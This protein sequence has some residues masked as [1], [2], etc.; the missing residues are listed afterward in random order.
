MKPGEKELADLLAKKKIADDLNE[1]EI[2]AREQ[3]TKAAEKYKAAI[4]EHVYELLRGLEW[5]KFTGRGSRG[6]LEADLPAKHELVQINDNLCNCGLPTYRT[7]FGSVCFRIYNK[8]WH[9]SGK[10]VRADKA[11]LVKIGIKLKRAVN[12]DRQKMSK[13]LAEHDVTPEELQKLLK[14]AKKA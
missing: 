2:V 7:H 8:G 14:K 4:T 3:A 10:Y 11:S 9:S 1:Q 5:K 6:E 13:M 12:K